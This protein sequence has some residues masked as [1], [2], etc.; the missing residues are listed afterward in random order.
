M[1]LARPMSTEPPSPPLPGFETVLVDA[2]ATVI[3][4]QFGDP[5]I[6]DDPVSETSA[7][8]LGMTA[9]DLAKSVLGQF[10]LQAAAT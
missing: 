8:L 5:A 7:L 6:N 2:I 10:S 3:Y 4:E 9:L 1:Y